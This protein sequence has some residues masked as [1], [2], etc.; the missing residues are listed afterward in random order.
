[1]DCGYSGNPAAFDFHHTDPTTKDY[2]WNRLRLKSWEAIIGELAK[3]VLLCANCHRI[4]HATFKVRTDRRDSNP[5]DPVILS[6]V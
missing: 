3:C 5:H 6:P 4:R 2:D 1:M